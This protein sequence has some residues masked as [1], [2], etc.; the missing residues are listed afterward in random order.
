MRPPDNV[1]AMKNNTTTKSTRRS[2]PVFAQ[3]VQLIPP[4]MI[5]KLAKSCHIKARVFSYAHQVYSLLLGQLMGAFSL[6]AKL[7]NSSK[8][9][10]SGNTA[11]TVSSSK[12][13]RNMTSRSRKRVLPK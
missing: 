13:R 7:R 1:G 5:E 2:L 10:R 4:G 3:I 11:L 9:S 6:N 12:L 8:T